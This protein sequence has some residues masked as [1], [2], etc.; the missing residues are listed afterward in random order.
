MPFG[1]Q[2]VL[3]FGERSLLAMNVRYLQERSSLTKN[4]QQIR[5]AKNAL[6]LNERSCLS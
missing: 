4:V 2:N 1:M 3:A 6:P 5:F